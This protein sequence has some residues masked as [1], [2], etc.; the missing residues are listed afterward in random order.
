MIK[1]HLLKEHAWAMYA[2]DENT[3]RGVA[4]GEQCLACFKVWQRW[5]PYMSW[6]QMVKDNESNK[7]VQHIVQEAKKLLQ[8]GQT[9]GVKKT[10]TKTRLLFSVE[11]QKPFLAGTMTDLKKKSCMERVPAKALKYVPKLELQSFDGGKPDTYYIFADPSQGSGS[12]KPVTLKV[13]AETEQ[14]VDALKVNEFITEAHAATHM[15]ETLK[16]QSQ[17]NGVANLLSKESY[18]QSWDEWFSKKFE[19]DVDAEACANDSPKMAIESTL[20]GPAAAFMTPPVK[21]AGKKYAQ[22]GAI[23]ALLRSNSKE[24]QEQGSVASGDAGGVDN[25][26]WHDGMSVMSVACSHAD[27]GDIMGNKWFGF[28]FLTT[29]CKMFNK[30]EQTC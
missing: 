8:E 16:M 5:F 24:S 28:S 1:P 26:T 9:D 17:S 30:F 13:T 23:G 22:E 18:L 4:A 20:V 3:V 21:V 25:A 11:M 29:S 10:A 27:G 19:E 2:K 7:E 14:E 12:L 15:T 6:Q